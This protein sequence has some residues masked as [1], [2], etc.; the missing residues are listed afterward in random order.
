MKLALMALA[1]EISLVRMFVDS[2]DWA[3]AFVVLYCTLVYVFMSRKV[4]L[5]RKQNTSNIKF[6]S[7][8]LQDSLNGNTKSK[9]QLY[10]RYA[11]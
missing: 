6:E 8:R 4:L 5:S 2:W 11:V 7:T 10:N 3:A 9:K 1:I